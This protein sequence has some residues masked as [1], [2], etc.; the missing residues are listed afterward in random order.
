MWT[1]ALAPAAMAPKEQSRTWAPTL[2]LIL[3]A[4]LAGSIDQL[5]PEPAG[6]GSWTV[7][8]VAV[9]GPPFLTVMVKPMSV[10]AL[11]GVASAF[12]V[13]DSDGHCTVMD[14]CAGGM[15][16]ELSAATVALL[17]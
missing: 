9:P 1:E 4:A 14:A 7:T 13:M 2:P 5:T 17:G 11:T 16:L 8:L 15:V 6:R 3:Q 12:L 10:P